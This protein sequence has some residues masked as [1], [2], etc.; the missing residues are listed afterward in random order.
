MSHFLHYHPITIAS[1]IIIALGILKG[2]APERAGA[3]LM[4]V[5]W[6]VEV[7]VDRLLKGGL[8]AV[9]PTIGLDAL[10]AGGLLILA[11]KYGKLWLG[12]AMMLQS[13]TLALHAM[14]LGDGAPGYNI[15]AAL[16]NV[17]TCL[18]VLSLLV[19]TVSAWRRRALSTAERSRSANPAPMPAHWVHPA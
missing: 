2:G 18:I 15:Y 8:I 14:A 16:L 3:L 11:L 9:S 6:L 10:L 7:G 5:E 1:A 17:T 4:A 19:G 12:A 13:V